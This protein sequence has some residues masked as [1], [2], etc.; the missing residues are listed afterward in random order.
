M[1]RAGR[2]RLRRPPARRS[3]ASRR[4]AVELPGSDRPRTA[5]G[6][7]AARPA[8]PHRRRRPVR[9][10]NRVAGS[11]APA[12]RRGRHGGVSVLA[13]CY[14]LL[15]TCCLLLAACYLLLAACCLLEASSK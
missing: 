1:A 12:V 3:P 6:E 9:I 8:R 7:R 4:R 10:R 14:L 5:V 2:R 13:T 15:A 11:R